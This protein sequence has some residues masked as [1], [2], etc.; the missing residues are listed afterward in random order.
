GRP[1]DPTI[2]LIAGAA[3]AM[4]W[5][6]DGFCEAL[7]SGPR[8][9]VRYD[10]RDTGRSVSSAPG[11]PDYTG[12]DLRDDAIGILDALGVERAHLAGIS[13]GGALAQELAVEHP[14]RVATL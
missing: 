11:E 9:V 12:A 6:E 2:L 8:H 14:K 7:A 4:D 1:S 10:F 5:W 13:M 3:S